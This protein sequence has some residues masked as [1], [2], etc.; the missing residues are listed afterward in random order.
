MRCPL[1]GHDDARIQ[2]NLPSEDNS[3]RS[4]GWG[5]IRNGLFPAAPKPDAAPP[6]QQQ[7]YHMASVG[8]PIHYEGQ[9]GGLGGA[10]PAKANGAP[11]PAPGPNPSDLGERKMAIGSVRANI[12]AELRKIDDDSKIGHRQGDPGRIKVLNQALTQLD[13]VEK[14]GKYPTVGSPSDEA[15]GELVKY[16]EKNKIAPEVIIGAVKQAA[17]GGTPS[18]T[19]ALAKDQ[20]SATDSSSGL[21][22]QKVD[23]TFHKH[24]RDP[25]FAND[26]PG[27]ADPVE[28][29]STGAP[30]IYAHGQTGGSIG[31]D[32][33]KFTMLPVAGLQLP[34]YKKAPDWMRAS[35]EPW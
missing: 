26:Y 10:Q 12:Y 8:A 5:F 7:P 23:A 33:K 3:W 30:V 1:C 14:Q 22:S 15:V 2:G 24:A 29:L 34:S 11:A 6:P 21:F 32:G 28:V 20:N 17:A 16:A 27:P 35:F 4:A 19:V 25:F 9:D 31:Y 18:Y 13:E